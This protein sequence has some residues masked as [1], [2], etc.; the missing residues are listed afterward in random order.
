MS[1]RGRA[2]LQAL[3]VTF[4][5]ST[6]WVLIK[7]GLRADFPALTFAGLRYGLAFLCLAPF[8]LFNAGHRAALRALPR[9]AWLRLTVL[10][11]V[12]YTLTQGAQF[13]GLVYLPAATLT[14]LLNLSPFVVA[15]ASV[16]LSDERPGRRQWGGILLS[17]AGAAVYF[18]PRAGPRAQL[19]GLAV[20]VVALLANAVSALL[21]RRVN[22]DGRLSPLLVTAVSMGIGGGVLLAGGVATQGFGQL[23]STNWWI[24]AWLALVNT[25]L[26]FTLWN[27]SLRELT[28]VESSV[29]N[30]TMMPQIAILA[31]AFL[32][33]ALN[34]RQIVALV[35][36]ALGTTM[37]QSGSKP[38][39]PRP[40]RP[41]PPA[42]PAAAPPS[43]PDRDRPR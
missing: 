12:F 21:G 11:L 13:V 7:L 24:V 5:W 42:L 41:S 30:N 20:G 18:F 34:A 25:A 29:I 27:R 6:S 1:P 4:L 19:V 10:G 14:L 2:I 15:L 16:Y 26:A 17:V 3:L 39:A 43:P 40:P 35:L 36:V 37:V 9:A 23:A 38:A 28:A 22:R 31:W 8:V 33:E 32:G